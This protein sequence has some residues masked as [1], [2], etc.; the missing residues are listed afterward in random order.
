MT[1]KYKKA[2]RKKMVTKGAQNCHLSMVRIILLFSP[3]DHKGQC[4]LCYIRY[5][6]LHKFHYDLTGI[7]TR[8]D[9]HVLLGIKDL[10][11]QRGQIIR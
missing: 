4:T 9:H 6:L 5:I 10:P 8:K 1:F 7:T 3:T 11:L 2:E